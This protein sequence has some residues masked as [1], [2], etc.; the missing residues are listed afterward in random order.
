MIRIHENDKIRIVYVDCNYKNQSI[1]IASNLIVV[2][3]KQ[4][5]K[6][7]KKLFSQ[8]EN[9]YI[10]L[11]QYRKKSSLIDLK[12]LLII[13][14]NKQKRI[15]II[16]NVFDEYETTYEKKHFLS[17]FESLLHKFTKIFVTNRFYNENIRHVF[18]DVF[19]ISITISKFDIEQFV[20]KQM[21]DKNKFFKQ[22]TTT[23]KNQ[24]TN[25]I[26]FRT[27]KM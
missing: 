18:D 8:F 22:T 25:T 10:K 13:L 11:E 17:L 21:F 4:L 9:M 3:A 15:Y 23:L 7:S 24:I 19:Q 6:H 26:C 14:C 20:Q 1:Q 5:V 16:I 2:F 12:Q 27:L